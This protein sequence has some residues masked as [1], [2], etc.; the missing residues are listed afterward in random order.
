MAAAPE[1][2]DAGRRVDPRRGLVQGGRGL[3]IEIDLTHAPAPAA[4]GVLGVVAVGGVGGRL[5][6][7][8]RGGGEGRKVRRM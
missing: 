7:H 8:E 6:G 3:V 2:R 1:V 5:V 4:R